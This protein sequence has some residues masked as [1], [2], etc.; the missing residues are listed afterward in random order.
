LQRDI[1]G[2]ALRVV[3][4]LSKTR[5][6]VGVRELSRDLG[7]AVASTHR[8]LR[9]LCRERLAV[10]LGNRGMYASGSRLAEIAANLV[11]ANDL[12]PAALPHLREVAAET[13]ESA[14]MMVVEGYEAVCVSSIESEQFLRVVFPVGWRGP[15][16]RGASGR[17]L[18]TYQP[19]TVIDAVIA[20]GKRAAGTLRITDAEELRRGLARIRRVGHCASHGEREEGWSSVAAAVRGPD[21]AVIAAVAVYGPSARFS[22]VDMPRQIRHATSC[23][24]AVSAAL[25]QRLRRIDRR[26]AQ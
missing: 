16:Y 24:A 5:D 6:A 14:L 10:Q 15:L 9:A 25:M 2:S 11:H 13:G 4:H 1:L 12:V 21:G 7:I 17:L 26:D 22:R 18:L 3:E 23:A 19:P 20:K 8:I